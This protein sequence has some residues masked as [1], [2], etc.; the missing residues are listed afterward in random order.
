M[1]LLRR[2]SSARGGL[3]VALTGILALLMSSAAFAAGTTTIYGGSLPNGTPV[4][5]GP[6]SGVNYGATTG[7][8]FGVDMP[9]NAG[10][11]WSQTASLGAPSGLSFVSVTASRSFTAPVSGAQYQP[12]INTTWEN[13]GMQNS[14]V[15]YG[16]DSGSGDIAVNNPSS[17]SITVSCVWFGGS[18]P[19][20]R[21][22]GGGH[23]SA[24]RMTYVLRDDN[25]PTGSLVSGGGA[26]LDGSWHTTATA[27]LTLNAGDDAAGIYR[28]FIREGA[29]TYYASV[30]PSNTRCQDARPGAGNDYEFAAAPSTLVPCRVAAQNYTPTFGLAAIGD[31][32]HTVD[33]GIEDASGREKILASNRTLKINVPG[34]T[35]PD[36]GTTGPGGCIYQ[37]DGTTCVPVPSNTT[38]PTITGGTPT[39]GSASSADKGAWSDT[40]SA[41]WGYQWQ[42]CTSTSTASCSD[43]AGATSASYTPLLADVDNYLRVIVTATNAGAPPTSAT[44]AISA[45]VRDSD[46]AGQAPTSNGG[47]AP[48]PSGGGGGGGGGGSKPDTDRGR[49]GDSAS[50]A[51]TPVGPGTRGRGA[52]NGVP[53]SDRVKLKAVFDRT[54]A[55]SLRSTYGTRVLIAGVLTTAAGDPI[56]GAKITVTARRANGTRFDDRGVITN[57]AG[58]YSATL[59]GDVVGQSIRVSYR[60][61][62]NDEVIA[63]GGSKELTLRVDARATLTVK[64]LGLKAATRAKS[65]KRARAIVRNGATLVFRVK[66]AGPVPAG[67][68]TIQLQSTY[69]GSRK[70]WTNFGARIQKTNAKGVFVYRV[71][72]QGTVG[73]VQYG[74]RVVVPQVDGGSESWPFSTGISPVKSLT[75]HGSRAR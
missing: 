38:A 49:P 58:A 60:S 54:K 5:A 72:T 73:K 24:S 32:T 61:H 35:L 31:G 62:D 69:K 30:D 41:T 42:R 14:G 15:G 19:S 52:A 20:P 74:F 22:T 68:K 37:A 67:G 43:I 28:A 44:S 39:R 57:K 63:E 1:N 46:P 3:L 56:Q 13:R 51:S 10:A 64:P 34:N 59:P 9:A 4:P 25:P 7:G 71:R 16:G 21:C 65:A 6:W 47:H 75:I 12:Q 70:G 29:A 8:T 26:L 33:I 17:L 40:T 18:D 36:P 45:K 11:G 53:A 27:E 55:P 50:D 66:V 23:W 48:S 2:R